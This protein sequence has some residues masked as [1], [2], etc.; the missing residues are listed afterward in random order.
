MIFYLKRE[1]LMRETVKVSKIFLIIEK[2][3]KLDRSL[4]NMILA[5]G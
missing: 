5:L 3:Q 4:I 2:F 1:Y